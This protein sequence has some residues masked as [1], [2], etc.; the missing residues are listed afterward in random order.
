MIAAQQNNDEEK[1]KS[2]LFLIVS[3]IATHVW[4]V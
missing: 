1:S 3:G 2:Y 4:R